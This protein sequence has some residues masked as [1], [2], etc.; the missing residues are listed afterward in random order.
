MEETEAD[1]IRPADKAIVDRLFQHDYNDF[2]PK[3]G[4]KNGVRT[5]AN[6]NQSARCAGTTRVFDGIEPSQFNKSEDYDIK[7]A[8]EESEEDFEFQFAMLES[9]RMA[10]EREERTKQFAAFLSKIRQ[11]AKIDK[12]NEAFY[13]KLI[14]C[15]ET[16]ER[17]D[18]LFV[19]VTQDFFM[20]F[21]RVLDNM[22]MKPEDKSKL[23]GIFRVN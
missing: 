10:K 21:I 23:M 22:R 20:A 15:I 18:I 17:E 4:K 1:E 7:R 19:N 8:L 12:S 13:L 16:Y 5:S 2:V 3:R 11:F 14:G 9:K 6:K